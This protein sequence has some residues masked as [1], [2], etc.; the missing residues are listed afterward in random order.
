LIVSPY[1]PLGL[2]VHC[3]LPESEQGLSKEKT[4]VNEYLE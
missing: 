1:H 3:L 2:R 4:F